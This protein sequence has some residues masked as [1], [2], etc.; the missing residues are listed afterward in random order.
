MKENFLNAQA[1]KKSKKFAKKL[2][3]CTKLKIKNI[4][5][6][7]FNYLIKNLK[8]KNKKLQKIL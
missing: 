3:Y 8:C 7:I 5:K 2:F 4:L 1:I 6:F